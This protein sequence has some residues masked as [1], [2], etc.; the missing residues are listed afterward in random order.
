MIF[1]EMSKEELI[2]ILKRFYAK[3]VKPIPDK[4]R[5]VVGN[6]YLVEQ[7]GEDE[8]EVK[9]DHMPKGADVFEYMDWMSFDEV[10][11]FFPD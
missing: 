6:Y 11:E 2:S 3:L 1:E 9:I 5:F 8:I 7:V 10:K 4:P